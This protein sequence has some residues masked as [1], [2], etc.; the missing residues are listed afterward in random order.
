MST[1]TFTGKR[2]VGGKVEGEALVCSEP[3]CFLG[4]VDVN[5]GMITE[6]GHQLEGKSMKDKILVFPTGKGSTGGSYLIY[7]TAS[8]GMGPLAMLNRKVEVVTA[9]GCIIAEI[10]VIDRIEP[11]PIDVIKDGDY[12][13]VDADQG[14][15]TVI[16][17]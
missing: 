8:N 3:I 17:K 15:I 5:T 11:D 4:G 7:E 9:I 1:L 14:T 10:P 12:V 16:Q 13:I 6:K 2:I